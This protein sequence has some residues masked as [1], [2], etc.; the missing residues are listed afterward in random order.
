MKKLCITRFNDT[1]LSENIEWKKKNNI[2][3]CIYGS[4]VMIDS[5]IYPEEE[6]IVIE[7]NNSQNK[8]VGIGV[9]KN[10]LFNKKCTIYTDNNYNRYIYKS[11]YH[12][13]IDKLNKYQKKI[14]EV[15]EFLL[16]KGKSNYKRG[17]GIQQIPRYITKLNNINIVQFFNKIINI[18]LI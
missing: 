9:I 8:I 6:L 15:L 7:M 13:T 2:I 10:K 18:N 11:N 5:T 1:T 12:I 14:I 16:F 4:P 17:H 3:G